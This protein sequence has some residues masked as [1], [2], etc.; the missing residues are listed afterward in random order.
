M[1][2]NP[3]TVPPVTEVILS[4]VVRALDEK[5][6]MDLRVF[7]VSEQS[8]ITD[9]VVLATGTSEPHLRAL[10]IETERVL[11]SRGA[12][13]SGMDTGEKGSGWI[14]VDAYQVMVHLFV[15]EK[16]GAY[17]LEN[18]WKDAQEL[19]VGTLLAPPVA[20]RPPRPRARVGAKSK[21]TSKAKPAGKKKAAPAAGRARSAKALGAIKPSPRKP[22]AKRPAPPSDQNA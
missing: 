20:P 1:P 21:A 3:A 10:R 7:R 19:G 9:Y 4:A 14:V 16:R 22:R 2:E 11:D 18:L 12:R 8:T 5:K 15:A 6:A 17:R 13:I